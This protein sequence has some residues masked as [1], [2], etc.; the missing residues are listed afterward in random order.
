MFLSWRYMII[1]WLRWVKFGFLFKNAIILCMKIGSSTIYALLSKS[2]LEAVKELQKNGVEA[3]ELVW[4]Y[5]HSELLEKQAAELRKTGADFSMHLPYFSVVFSHPDSKK[6][7]SHLLMVEKALGVA[8]RLEAKYCVIHGGWLPDYYLKIDS[9]MRMEGFYDI[10]ARNFGKMFAKA[11]DSG[12]KIVLENMGSHNQ[13]AA[14]YEDI[15]EIQK[16]LPGLGFCLDIPHA[17]RAGGQELLDKFTGKMKIDHLHVTDDISR[18]DDH[19]SIGKGTL[20]IRET[21]QKLK[22]QGYG[23]KVIFEGLTFQD[24]LESVKRLKEMVG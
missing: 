14:S 11:S 6:T 3:I 18:R 21:L 17:I 23:G 4:E 24:T 7:D 13:I 16:R 2:P 20:P 8:E 15:L 5:R 19:I 10:Y 1:S 9:P 22:S 12:L